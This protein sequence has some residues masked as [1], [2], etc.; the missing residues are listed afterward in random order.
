MVYLGTQTSIIQSK[1]EYLPLLLTLFHSIPL[2]LNNY[3]CSKT[4]INSHFFL[5]DYY[6][7][8]QH[9]HFRNHSS[10][11]LENILLLQP[12]LP[13]FYIHFCQVCLLNGSVVSPFCIY[14]SLTQFRKTMLVTWMLAIEVAPSLL[15]AI[16]SSETVN[17]ARISVAACFHWEKAEPQSTLW[18]DLPSLL[19]G[20]HPTHPLFYVALIALLPGVSCFL[21]PH[22]LSAPFLTPASHYLHCLKTWLSCHLSK[23]S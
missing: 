13:S 15:P 2:I 14:T 11:E 16:C 3:K 21:T 18:A 1:S 19:S 7:D 23:V 5:L 6:H 12:F 17:S 4:T 20:F 8:W 9:Q 22:A 10:V